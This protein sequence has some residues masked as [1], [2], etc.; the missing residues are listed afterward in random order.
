MFMLDVEVRIGLKET[1]YILP[2]IHLFSFPF[3]F[4]HFQKDNKDKSG[5]KM[6]RNQGR[7]ILPR[8]S[9]K[10]EHFL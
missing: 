4:S 1:I 2:Q 5:K 8:N 3:S 9:D 10:N 7:F 6:S